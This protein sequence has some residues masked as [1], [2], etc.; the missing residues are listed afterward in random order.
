M[1]LL[2]AKI[3]KHLHMLLL[4]V[5]YW[6]EMGGIMNFCSRCGSKNDGNKFCTQCGN[7]LDN[8]NN[9][10]IDRNE[11]SGLKTASI[12]LG[13]LSIVGTFMIVFSPISF[14]LS[15]V[16]LILGIIS[17]NKVKNIFGIVLNSIGLLISIAVTLIMFFLIRYVVVSYNDYDKNY[18]Y[19]NHY[20]KFEL[21]D[22]EDYFD[23]FF[24]SNW[25]DN[26][27]Y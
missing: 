4:K 12:V 1:F 14:I 15:L 22:I 20:N 21:D 6:L 24:D 10:V 25:R 19:D 27:Y 3:I 13:I 5:N 11:K 18:Y 8:S 23:D 17:T 7:K 16:G 2:I 26:D 9:G